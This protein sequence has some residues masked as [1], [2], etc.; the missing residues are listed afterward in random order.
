MSLKIIN[1]SKRFENKL[2]LREVSFE[3]ECGSI[4]GILGANG[5]GKTTLLRIIS[6]A[7]KADSGN[8][9][10]DSKEIT[11]A[12]EKD[13]NFSFPQKNPDSAWSSVFKKSKQ[14]ELSEGEDQNLII[15]QLFETTQYAVL[16]DNP[17]SNLNEDLRDEALHH[18]QQL[19]KE[20]NL[21]VVFVT[22]DYKEAFKVCDK[23]GVLHNGGI[24]QIGTPREL[25]ENPANTAAARAL[26]RNNFIR[27][28]R[29]TFNNQQ[30]QEFQTIEGE[31]RLLIGKTEKRA[32]GAI[33]N[34]VILAIRPEH[35]SLS[36]GA[37]FPED[38]LLK[39]E[40]VGVQYLG[41]TT[42]IRL[43]A[44]G[45]R[46]EALVLRLVGLNVGDECMVGLPP[47]RISVLKD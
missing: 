15:K 9:F 7:E 6:G 37:S 25:Y 16:V 38:N 3:I 28:R 12:S 13:R 45:L 21:P 33:T 40:I 32:L 10:L 23:I 42:R 24:A 20:K 27:A 34:D 5:A 31:H 43:S 46:L 29:I 47:D 2:I 18:L 26:G 1:V 4:F 8:I 14:T 39:A 11:G 17:F 36:F 19:T 22:N 35:I 44:N 30:A 41:A